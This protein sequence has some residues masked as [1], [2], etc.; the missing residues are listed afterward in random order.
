M[1]DEASE[2]ATNR[3]VV[4]RLMAILAGDAPIENGAEL[5][6][7]DVVAH[8]D[9]WRFEGINVWAN[10]IRYI[11]TRR[12]AAEPML[13]IDE[14]ATE[15]DATVVVRGRWTR[16]HGARAAVSAQGEARYR[17]V[18]G[19]IVEMWS[20]R[21]NYAALCGAHLTTRVGFAVELLRVWWWKTRAPQLDLTS[22]APPPA[23]PFSPPALTA[24]VAATRLTR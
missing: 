5:M 6:T 2:A 19:R 7:A 22:P 23:L 1:R 24:T 9:G 21:G 15:G 11:H 3:A 20:T 17:L 18:G 16:G 10:W 14:I 4:A 13:L 12:R 8:V